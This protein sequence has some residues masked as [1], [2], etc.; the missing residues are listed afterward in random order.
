MRDAG[1]RV[2]QA[3]DT[4]GV[5]GMVVHALSSEAREF[6]VRLGFDLSPLDPMM[7]MVTLT[8]LKASL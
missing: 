7:L 1:L 8:D 4:I 2:I 5:R 3:A 6:Y